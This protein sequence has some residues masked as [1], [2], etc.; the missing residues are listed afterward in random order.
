MMQYLVVFF[1]SVDDNSLAPGLN[2]RKALNISNI[3]RLTIVQPRELSRR[4][5]VDNL[6]ARGISAKKHK[7]PSPISQI[8][9][10]EI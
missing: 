3:E 5:N 4:E 9:Y 2:D 8:H 7:S 6:S 1:V 10:A